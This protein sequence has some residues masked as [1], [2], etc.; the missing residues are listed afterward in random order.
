MFPLLVCYSFSLFNS[1]FDVGW[2]VTADLMASESL[3]KR[4]HLTSNLQLCLSWLMSGTKKS[5]VPSGQLKYLIHIF[6]FYLSV[7]S[8]SLVFGSFFF[9]FNQ[10]LLWAFRHHDIVRYCVV[11]KKKYPDN[12]EKRQLSLSL[13]FH[14]YTV[15]KNGGYGRTDNS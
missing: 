14:K 10:D 12:P 5:T 13:L 1:C 7:G 11:T 9:F 8:F 15:V 3:Q 6:T 4:R 2:F